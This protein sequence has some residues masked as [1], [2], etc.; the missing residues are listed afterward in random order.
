M[1]YVSNDDVLLRLGQR[2]YVQLSDDAGS[3]SANEAVIDAA[4]AAAEG[5]VN[6]YLARRYRVPLDLAAHPELNAILAAV[7][8]DVV[9]L[10]LHA[11][12]PPVPEHITLRY[13]AALDW[14]SRVGSGAAALPAESAPAAGTVT[15]AGAVVTGE[16]VTLSRAELEGL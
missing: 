1:A 2:A 14:L 13:R 12:R 8:L 9:E 3:G 5:E 10:R 11:R 15:G 4:R 7:T 16:D 6:S